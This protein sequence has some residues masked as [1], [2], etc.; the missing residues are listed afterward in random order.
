[1]IGDEFNLGDKSSIKKSMVGKGC[2]IGEKVKI[3]NSIIMDNVKI[4]E[5]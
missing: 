5:G 1:M 3:I 4:K 2:Q